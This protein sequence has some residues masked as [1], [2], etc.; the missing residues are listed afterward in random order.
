MALEDLILGTGNRKKGEELAALFAATG[1]RIATLADT[2]EPIEVV[3][4]GDT[5][6]ANAAKKATQQAVHLAAWVLAEDSGLAV[7]ALDGAPGVYSARFAGP[8]ATDARNNALLLEKLA[9]LPPGRRGA[10]Y[11]CHMTLA[12]PDGQIRA[13]TTGR[14]RGRIVEQPRG[15]HGFGYDP[16]FEILEYH[17]TFAEL[18]PVVK[19]RISHRARAADRMFAELTRLV[20]EP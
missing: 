10:A 9:G 5:F 13:E 18:G 4:D 1:L 7:E 12:D 2:A 6:A 16:L 14:C 11:V 20:A 15:Q 3:E 8:E 19:S 17:R